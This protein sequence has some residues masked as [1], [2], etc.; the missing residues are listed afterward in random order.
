MPARQPQ[1]A[2]QQLEMQL[3]PP[4]M[5]SGSPSTVCSSEWA[6]WKP[7]IGELESSPDSSV[8][9]SDA[10]SKE[11]GAVDQRQAVAAELTGQ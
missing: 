1:K 2:P 11:A 6:G 8:L 9:K 10:R 7:S 5:R 4:R 3:Q